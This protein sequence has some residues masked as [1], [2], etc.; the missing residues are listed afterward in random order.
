MLILCISIEVGHRFDLWDMDWKIPLQFGFKQIYGENGGPGGLFHSLRIIPPYLRF[1][2]TY[3]KFAQK[4]LY[5]IIQIL[6][7][8]FVTPLRQSF[9]NLNLL[10]CVMKFT[11]WKCNCLCF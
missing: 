6:C 2:R 8:V 3:K 9:L 1:V 5:S 4:H 11:Q 7:N 10:V